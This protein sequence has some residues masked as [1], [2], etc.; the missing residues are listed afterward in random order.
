MLD[1]MFDVP[2][3]PEV[4]RCEISEETVRDGVPPHL[5]CEEPLEE[6]EEPPLEQTA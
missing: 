3:R 1:V 6:E 5:V 4:V 2:G